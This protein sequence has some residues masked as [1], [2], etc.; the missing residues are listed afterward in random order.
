[1]NF[2]F[3]RIS[4]DARL[5]YPLLEEGYLTIGFSYLLPKYGN[6]VDEIKADAIDEAKYNQ[7]FQETY[8]KVSRNRWYLWDFAK[9]AAG[10]WVVVPSWGTFAVYEVLETAKSINNLPPD[11]IADVKDWNGKDIIFDGVGLSDSDKKEYDLGFFVKV[12]PVTHY[13]N[14]TSFAPRYPFLKSGLTKRLKSRGTNGQLNDLADEVKEAVSNVNNNKP[15]NFYTTVSETLSKSLKVLIQKEITS[16]KFEKLV[17]WYMKK[18]GADDVYIPAK[19]STNKPDDGDS[20]VIASFSRL[21]LVVYIQAKH[22]EGI[23]A[24]K[25]AITQ[26]QNYVDAVDNNKSTCAA[27]VISSCDEYSPEVQQAALQ[28]SLQ[29]SSL[30]IR[31]INGGEFAKMLLDVGFGD[32]VTAKSPLPF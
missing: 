19:N 14:G 22:Y 20:D 8:N 3:H 31:L 16:D 5:S 15:L 32:L 27:W 6:V 24:N 30:P 23:Q 18:L 21:N 17:E 26:I 12:K 1:M 9:F 29:N 10:D 25:W 7:I 4:H 2:W 11:I 28:Q 13:S